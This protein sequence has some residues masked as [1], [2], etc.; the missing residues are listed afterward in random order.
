MNAQLHQIGTQLFSNDALTIEI[1]PQSEIDL[2]KICRTCLKDSGGINELDSEAVFLIR[3]DGNLARLNEMFEDSTGLKVWMPLNYRQ[4]LKTN[5]FFFS[6][7]SMEMTSY[8][9]IS[10]MLAYKMLRILTVF[11][12]R[13]GEPIRFWNRCW[14]WW[15][16]IWMATR[17]RRHRNHKKK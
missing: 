4:S 3:S 11:V 17:R 1:T 2:S 13:V 14:V 16:T 5:W 7:S 10:A 15:K 6:N 9:L 8:Q 12:T